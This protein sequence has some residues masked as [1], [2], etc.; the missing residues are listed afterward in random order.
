MKLSSF[1]AAIAFTAAVSFSSLAQVQTAGSLI[2]EVNGQVHRLNPGDSCY[3]DSRLP[4]R[5]VNDGDEPTR[6]TLAITPPSY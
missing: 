6:F 3:F 5:Y 2:V 1:L 4:H